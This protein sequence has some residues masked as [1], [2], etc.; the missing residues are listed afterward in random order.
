M[1]RL[2]RYLNWVTTHQGDIWLAAIFGLFF[3]LILDVLTPEGRIRT[4][5]GAIQN[6]LAEQSEARL[7]ERI[8]ELERQRNKYTAYLSSDKALYLASFQIVIAMLGAL[9]VGALLSAIAYLTGYPPMEITAIPIYIVAFALAVQG[10]R[11]SSLDTKDKVAAMV[12]KLDG[13]INDLTKKL[14]GF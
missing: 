11:I 10:A 3:A 8:K 6:K 7:R 1:D 2:H 9:G 14:V 5:I 12:E 13:E 4:L